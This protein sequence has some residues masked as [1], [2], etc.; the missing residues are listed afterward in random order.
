MMP[1]HAKLTSDIT[2]TLSPA[3]VSTLAI[4]LDSAMLHISALATHPPNHDNPTPQ[5]TAHREWIDAV[6]DLRHRIIAA[7]LAGI[8]D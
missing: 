1:F 5:Q 3:D 8:T 7:A 2:I 6:L 4:A